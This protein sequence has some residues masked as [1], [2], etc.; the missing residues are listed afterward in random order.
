MADLLA[1]EP[2]E[3][4]GYSEVLVKF[5]DDTQARVRVMEDVSL[6]EFLEDTAVKSLARTGSLETPQYSD[7]ILYE[8][9]RKPE[10]PKEELSYQFEAGKD[11]Y[12]ITLFGA[13]DPKDNATFH[14]LYELPFVLQG[15][16]FEVIALNSSGSY[17]DSLTVYADDHADAIIEGLQEGL[18]VGPVVE[19]IEEDL[20][21]S[22]WDLFE[23]SEDD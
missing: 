22:V 17:E 23:E 3:H 1:L 18:F 13:P 5:E 14:L 10:E 9:D 6:P 7:V 4:W 16:V 8:R 19:V 11:A 2:N 12:R 15:K 21:G 20:A